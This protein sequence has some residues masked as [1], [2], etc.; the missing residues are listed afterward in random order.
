MKPFKAGETV[1]VFAPTVIP[2]AYESWSASWKQFIKSIDDKKVTLLH[3]RVITEPGFTISGWTI[4]FVGNEQASDMSWVPAEWMDHV[5]TR[6]G[7]LFCT[8]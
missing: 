5:I 6:Q 7:C 4:D 3:N 1:V 2:P 8:T